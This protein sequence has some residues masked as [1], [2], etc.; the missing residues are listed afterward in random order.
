TFISSIFWTESI[1]P[2]AALKTLEVMERE[3]SWETITNMRIEITNRWKQLADKFEFN[4]AT[5]GLPALNGFSFTDE[6]V[7][8]YKTLL[9][10]EMLWKGYLASNSVYV[11]TEHTPDIFD[12]YFTNLEPVFSLMKECEQGRDIMSLLKGS[13]C[14]SGFKRLN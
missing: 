1:G 7:L 4:I 10:Q 12:G 11:C 14:H 13:I 8:A 2:T 5:W 6:N 3:K 9:T